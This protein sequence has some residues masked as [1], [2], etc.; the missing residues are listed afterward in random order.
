MVPKLDTWAS[1]H[2]RVVILGDAAHAIPPTAGQGINQAFED[3]YIYA[4]I[5]SKCQQHNLE[6]GLKVW[7]KGRQERV[8]RVLDLN[9]QIDARRM[10]KNPQ[11]TPSDLD[12]KSFDLAWLYSPNFDEMAESWLAGVG[13]V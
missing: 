5:L 6:Q 12:S 4:L 13:I 10:P 11:A 2:S 9:A 7:Q 8:D 1:K 3:V